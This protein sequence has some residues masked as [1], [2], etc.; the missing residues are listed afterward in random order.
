MEP[1]VGEQKR[2]QSQGRESAEGPRRLST[3]AVQAKEPELGM[4]TEGLSQMTGNL[5]T[6]SSCSEKADR[7]G[8][9]KQPRNGLLPAAGLLNVLEGLLGPDFCQGLRWDWTMP[10]TMFNT[11]FNI[12]CAPRNFHS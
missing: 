7:D 6:L 1:Q 10:T 8:L 11:Q 3:V 12:L 5:R 4:R 2:N 9:D